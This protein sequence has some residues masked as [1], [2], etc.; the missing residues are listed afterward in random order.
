[1]KLDYIHVNSKY[2][3]INKLKHLYEHAFPIE[4]RPPFFW[5]REMK[6]N[7]LYAVELDST[8]VGLVDIVRCEDLLYVFFLA[9]KKT[10]RGKGIGATILDDLYKKYN[11]Y[12]LFLM[13]ENP[14]VS[15]DNKEERIHRIN[16]YKKNNYVVSNHKVQEFGVDYL[17]L[18][19]SKEVDKDDFLKCMKLVIEKEFYENIYLKNVK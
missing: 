17:I 13:A 15:C 5:L 16:F 2:K 4:E 11:N 10:Y 12:R 8:F 1:M 14:N 7:E 18:Y 3:D 6:N 19:R 9:V